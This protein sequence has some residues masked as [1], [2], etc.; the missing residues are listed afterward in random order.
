MHA[1]TPA[2][3]LAILIDSAGILH[4]ADAVRLLQETPEE[5]VRIGSKLR[6]AERD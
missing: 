1:A 5:V 2:E 6:P 3:R 4:L